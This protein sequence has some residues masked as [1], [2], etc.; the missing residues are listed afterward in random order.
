MISEREQNIQPQNV[1]AGVQ[2]ILPQNMPL[3]CADYVELEALAIQQ[4]MQGE[5]FSELPLSS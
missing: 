1:T 2:D 3:W 4:Q 5:A